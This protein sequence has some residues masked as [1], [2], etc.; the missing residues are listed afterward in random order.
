MAPRNYL[1]YRHKFFTDYDLW[2]VTTGEL[3]D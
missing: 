2:A 1:D 3:I